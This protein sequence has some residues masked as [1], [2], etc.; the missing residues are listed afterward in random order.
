M[1]LYISLFLSVGD[2][3]PALSMLLIIFSLYSIYIKKIQIYKI[4]PIGIVGIFLMRLIGEGRVSGV[5]G[6]DG[7]II[8]RGFDSIEYSIDGYYNMTL[9]FVINCW[10]LYIG[11]EYVDIN[12]MDWLTFLKRLLGVVPFLQGL[13][14]STGLVE[15][16]SPSEIFTQIGL[17]DNPTWGLGTN[18]ISSV[19]IAYGLF[20]CVILFIMLGFIVENFRISLYRKNNIFSHIIYFTLLGYAVYYPRTDFLMPLKFIVWTIVIY[21][22]LVNFKFLV[23]KRKEF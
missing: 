1:I 21:I 6:V 8:T 18:L 15:L 10:T 22:I 19:Y 2:R 9:D 20:G 13:V 11:V 4:I 12:G 14:E 5:D 23:S 16:T 17:G 3:G 7:N